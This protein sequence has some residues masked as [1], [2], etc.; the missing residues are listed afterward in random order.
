MTVK[1]P[2]YFSLS[3]NR[4]PDCLACFSVLSTDGHLT[5]PTILGFV[6]ILSPHFFLVSYDAETVK[7]TIGSGSDPAVPKFRHL[8][9]GTHV[10]M[11]F[12]SVFHAVTL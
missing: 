10:S 7:D 1:R 9:V 2:D 8:P 12:E 4:L 3:S 6:V 5:A 11:S